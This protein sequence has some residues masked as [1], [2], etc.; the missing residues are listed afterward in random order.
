MLNNMNVRKKITIISAFLLLVTILVALM[1][2]YN[3]DRNSK[4][5]NQMYEYN[6]K[7]MDLAADLRT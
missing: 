6:L 4:M 1:G 7:T 2:Y 5:M 3:A